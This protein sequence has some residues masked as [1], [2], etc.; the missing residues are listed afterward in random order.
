MINPL[1]R[2][3]FEFL[4]KCMYLSIRVAVHGRVLK[5]GCYSISAAKL[6]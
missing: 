6:I 3:Q 4:A 5:V 2:V 1:A